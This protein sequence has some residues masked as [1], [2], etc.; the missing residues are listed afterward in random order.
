[1]SATAASNLTES[2]LARARRAEADLD[3]AAAAPALFT[4]EWTERALA[5][6]NEAM[7][8]ARY[9]HSQAVTS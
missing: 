4:P 7:A 9:W 3:A 6:F 8:W 1:M 5:E 2:W